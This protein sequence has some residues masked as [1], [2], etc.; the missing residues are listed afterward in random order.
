MDGSFHSPVVNLVTWISWSWAYRLIPPVE[1]QRQGCFAFC[2]AYEG[3]LKGHSK[4]WCLPLFLV[5][6]V[7]HRVLHPKW[8]EIGKKKNWCWGEL[9]RQE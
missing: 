4:N 1:S 3:V 2:G 7:L 6:N 5:N 9:P 8:T